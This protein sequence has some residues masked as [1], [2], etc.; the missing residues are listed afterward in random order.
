MNNEADDE[1]LLIFSSSIKG[2]S[3]AELYDIQ[4]DNHCELCGWKLLFVRQC[5]KLLIIQWRS[6]IGAIKK[7]LKMDM[8]I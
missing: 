1:V 5:Q 8:V 6:A 7:Q 4:E 2:P 3:N